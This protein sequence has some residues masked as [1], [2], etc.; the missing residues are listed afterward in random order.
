[1]PACEAHQEVVYDQKCLIWGGGGL[2][3]QRGFAAYF[4]AAISVGSQHFAFSAFDCAVIFV[5][6]RSEPLSLNCCLGKLELCMSCCPHS[7]APHPAQPAAVG[8]LL[9]FCK[10]RKSDC[11]TQSKQQHFHACDLSCNCCIFFF[12]LSS[13]SEEK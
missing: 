10:K 4:F 1:M 5:T 13:Q 11:F 6:A 2:A 3:S 12:C 7:T 9:I 8:A